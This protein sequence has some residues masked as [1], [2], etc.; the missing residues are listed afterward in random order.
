MTERPPLYFVRHGETEWN[1]KFRIQGRTDI[2]LNAA[3]VAQA[4]AI[5]QRLAQLTLDDFFRFFPGEWFDLTL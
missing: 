4:A 3:G 2:P 5:G 1:R